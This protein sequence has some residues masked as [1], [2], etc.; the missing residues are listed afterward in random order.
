MA[1][2]TSLTT[3]DDDISSNHFT[4]GSDVKINWSYT[5]DINDILIDKIDSNQNK[6]VL[7]DPAAGAG[8]TSAVITG[9]WVW[10]TRF[11]S[12]WRKPSS[13]SPMYI[14]VSDGTKSATYSGMKKYWTSHGSWSSN[15]GSYPNHS[16]PFS[17]KSFKYNVP[18]NMFSTGS[19]TV[20][21]WKNN[22]VE[23]HMKDCKITFSDGEVFNFTDRDT[24]TITYNLKMRNKTF[25]F[26]SAPPVP[27][28]SDLNFTYKIPNNT[29]NGTY[30]FELYDKLG[31]VPKI[32]KII[33]VG[34]QKFF[35]K[36]EFDSKILKLTNESVV[37]YTK[38]TT[39]DPYLFSTET[40]SEYKI[41]ST[42][43][44]QN[45]YKIKWKASSKIS[46]VKIELHNTT[47]FIKNISTNINGQDL[48]YN[49][50]LN[51]NKNL[52]IFNE[53]GSD[54]FIKIIDESNA[55]LH[56]SS[57]PFSIKKLKLNISSNN[58]IKNNTIV[59]IKWETELQDNFDILL[60][61]T[62]STQANGLYVINQPNFTGY[63]AE[64]ISSSANYYEWNVPLNFI[65]PEENS[66][67]YIE[68]LGKNTGI[69]DTI[70]INFIN[71]IINDIIFIKSDKIIDDPE[72]FG[73]TINKLK[74]NNYILVW[75]QKL[76]GSQPYRLKYKIVNKD[77][78]TIRTEKTI[79]MSNNTFINK[80]L[81]SQLRNKII[82]FNDG[83]ILLLP[84]HYKDN[85]ISKWKMFLYF[86]DFNG[87]LDTTTYSH[88][89]N[90]KIQ[91]F[92]NA[93]P[94]HSTNTPTWDNHNFQIKHTDNGGFIILK[95]TENGNT[96]FRE[97]DSNAKNIDDDI[98]LFSDPLKNKYTIEF[99]NL[100]IDSFM[101]F[102]KL[103]STDLTNDPLYGKKFYYEGTER[104]MI[105][106]TGQQNINIY[107]GNFKINKIP[108]LNKIIALNENHVLI[109]YEIFDSILEIEIVKSKILNVTND[110]WSIISFNLSNTPKDEEIMSKII[111]IDRTNSIMEYEFYKM[112]DELIFKYIT[113]ENSKKI[114]NIKFF[115]IKNDFKSIKQIYNEFEFDYNS[116]DTTLSAGGSLNESE[117]KIILSDDL[118]SFNLYVS[119][120]NPGL[121]NLVFNT[122][123][124]NSIGISSP[125][126]PNLINIS[127]VKID[128]SGNLLE[129]DTIDIKLIKNNK[130]TNT[131]VTDISFTDLSYNFDIRT[132]KNSLTLIGINSNPTIDNTYKFLVQSN[133]RYNTSQ[134]VY[135]IN[136]GTIDII[137]YSSNLTCGEN[138]NIQWEYVGNVGST[139]K[140]D[141][142]YQSVTN[143]NNFD[144]S[145]NIQQS[146]NVGANNSGSYN[147]LIPF[148]NFNN[149][150]YKIKL[151]SNQYSNKYSDIIEPNITS[152]QLPKWSFISY[153][154]EITQGNPVNINW[155]YSGNMN[156]KNQD[157]YNIKL[158]IIEINNTGFYTILDN[159][160]HKTKNLTWDVPF[161]SN[162]VGDF[163]LKIS[164]LSG[165][166]INNDISG[167]VFSFIKPEFKKLTIPSTIKQGNQVNINWDYSGNI[168]NIKID[169]Y[170]SNNNLKLNII[171]NSNVELKTYNWN[172]P[173]TKDISG[174][175]YK[176]KIQDISSNA[177]IFSS[178]SFGTVPTKIII[179][180]TLESSYNQN[181]V[182][183]II[184][185]FSGNIK[186]IKLDLLD[187]NNLQYNIEDN[188]NLEALSNNGTKPEPKPMQPNIG[189]NNLGSSSHTAEE[190]CVVAFSII[191]NDDS[192]S[193][194]SDW[195]SVLFK[196][197]SFYLGVY[198]F[199][200]SSQPLLFIP[201]LRNAPKPSNFKRIQIYQI[202]FDTPPTSIVT[203]AQDYYKPSDFTRYTDPSVDY[204]QWA[205][206]YTIKKN[207]SSSWNST[208]Y[209]SNIKYSWTPTLSNTL[210]GINKF[211]LKLSDK[212]ELLT[213]TT[214]Y[215][216]EL[217]TIVKQSFNITKANIFTPTK[218]LFGTDYNINW[219]YTLNLQSL[220]ID[221]MNDGN[222]I[223]NIVDDRSVTNE[224]YVLNIPVTKNY[225]LN[226]FSATKWRPIPVYGPVKRLGMQHAY[227]HS[228]TKPYDA[229]ELYIVIATSI[230]YTDGVESSLSPWRC[231][232]WSYISNNQ[233][234]YKPIINSAQVT[235][236]APSQPSGFLKR[237]I[238]LYKFDN[239][240][241]VQNTPIG[242]PTWNFDNIDVNTDQNI[243]KSNRFWIYSSLPS[244]FGQPHLT[245]VPTWHEPGV[246][247]PSN[248]G[249]LSTTRSYSPSLY[250]TPFYLRIRDISG[251]ANDIYSNTFEIINGD[252]KLI[253]I[254]DNNTIVSDVSQNENYT[255]NWDYS[256]NL[257]Y[258][259]LDLYQNGDYQE[260]IVNNYNI[261]EK[262]YPWKPNLSNTVAGNTFW[263]KISD[264]YGNA[265]TY[266]SYAFSI[267]KP[268][269]TIQQSNIINNDKILLGSSYNINWS[270]SL[271]IKSIQI[272][273]IDIDGTPKHTIVTDLDINSTPYVWN[274]SFDYLDP[275]FGVLFNLDLTKD[276][277][278]KISDLSGNA[279]SISSNN[280][281]IIE[282]GFKSLT[283]PS[284]SI[285]Q[286]R[287]YTINWDYDGN[288]SKV[289]ID[290]FDNNNNFKMNIIDNSN[291]SLKSY[292]WTPD[293][294]KNMLQTN[295]VK[296]RI[297]DIDPGF[298]GHFD[299]SLFIIVKPSLSIFTTS[300]Q[301]N[302]NK[303][304]MSDNNTYDISWN[305]ELDIDKI[306]LFL[307]KNNNKVLINNSSI[308][309]NRPVNIKPYI[310]T[311]PLTNNNV[312]D[313]S[314]TGYYIRIE[315]YDDI[316]DPVDSPTFEIIAPKF[317]DLTIPSTINQ[318]QN[319]II[320]WDYIGNINTI[321]IDLIDADDNTFFKNIID[322]SNVS[323]KTYS[324]KPELNKLMFGSF[325]LKITDISGFSSSICSSS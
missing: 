118:Q 255:I 197:D 83:Y 71:P 248:E 28:A 160:N 102:Y 193:L 189:Y 77:Y 209:I 31:Q 180:N 306:N 86:Y 152:I 203:E 295:N 101:F 80:Y 267:I 126:L 107:N 16:Y 6:T 276:F 68:I 292:T 305:F 226:N 70:N 154:N 237:N 307:M 65:H 320:N 291:A 14:K 250:T 218:I 37:D 34:P 277:T 324:W 213:L 268:S 283:L 263:V 185:D 232:Y 162:F 173:Y 275:T 72:S 222:V 281:K 256:G 323:L 20:E 38:I 46:K 61:N 178:S 98:I 286:N 58:S 313:I 108:I 165:H 311:L 135:F 23:V 223:E 210:Y 233:Y 221:L 314:G 103:Y 265:N 134:D 227:Y 253:N 5:G 161:N 50:Y 94:I 285:N 308:V 82:H 269:F 35:I 73:H 62:S 139:F 9:K 127:T 258:I 316:A 204:T 149:T 59:K 4:Q 144:L 39:S 168:S 115:K 200:K 183:D 60:K 2:F 112:N 216:S 303:V 239:N 26:G 230:T 51:L 257:K 192:E 243:L 296:L 93:N 174:S 317:T 164:D 225:K 143:S 63:I 271:I 155:D 175:G 124:I 19:L 158:E 217:F 13:W 290:L 105:P 52:P 246:N 166:S 87:N 287:P 228:L 76:S 104:K 156:F 119:S 196:S 184:L 47:G 177:T 57:F 205:Y 280:F 171:D 123:S 117:N 145:Y 148:V 264:I 32:Q 125:T 21:F 91:A 147:W 109:P 40:A 187:S 229:E 279:D 254:K 29:L 128:W 238:Y 130:V 312:S 142:I 106:K 3:F 153:S 169:L 79:D 294:S 212:E 25:S 299:S 234:Y 27:I 41:I 293:L 261:D 284:N 322:N 310:W 163:K 201:G 309:S 67:S 274:P 198:N 240:T 113:S 53:T 252:F 36:S 136:D 48:S 88:I 55:N 319:T 211:K 278:L 301:N 18:L 170:D 297:Y 45:T 199:G 304:I 181:E 249:G 272:D 259:K 78:T 194:L 270:H 215:I 110:S 138:Y 282:S 121:H 22:P 11:G 176:I 92:T 44:H 206:P 247:V 191:Y 69:N 81:T 289:K 43:K 325:K 74:N 89:S 288:V 188:V 10:L 75:Y 244:Y 208:N 262:S 266:D 64:N 133:D 220:K 207:T 97:Y 202:L 1:S 167:I 33:T 231:I 137:D 95:T 242:V 318:N 245:V 42:I 122:T 172:I 49:W 114:Q 7:I 116:H 54:F 56:M 111:N 146:I 140:L 129:T 302:N 300:I 235:T 141:L 321:E 179:S 182:Y 186:N 12:A 99:V 251:I 224:P 66:K 219:D 214:P 100:K 273:L 120:E 157:I 131:L 236:A 150:P 15:M 84:E 132:I 159:I 96:V 241:F 8:K 315:D 195:T 17:P 30:T 190:A 90:G 85:N 298:G 260:N 24:K 151:T